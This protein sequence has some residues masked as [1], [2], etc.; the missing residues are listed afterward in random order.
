[1]ACYCLND[2]LAE[3]ECISETHDPTNSKILNS[4]TLGATG[5]GTLVNTPIKLKWR[6]YSFLAASTNYISIP[7]AAWPGTSGSLALMLNYTGGTTDAL[8]RIFGT[9]HTSGANYEH[10]ASSNGQM[11]IAYTD[12][13]TTSGITWVPAGSISLGPIMMLV[14]TWSLSG[15]TTTSYFYHNGAQSATTSAAKTL[16][17]PDTAIWIGRYDTDYFTGSI[18]NVAFLPYPMT[19]SQVWEH[20]VHKM[21]SVNK[22]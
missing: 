13:T 16:Q 19:P 21:L 14:W 9:D 11:S 1:M 18:Y 6:G 17:T 15:G 4:G 10:R 8:T 7:L 22:V 20:Y 12:G 2:A 5:D 3:Y